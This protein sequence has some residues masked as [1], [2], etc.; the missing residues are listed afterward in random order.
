MIARP[1]A[2]EYAPFYAG[3]VQRIP[4]GSDLFTLLSGQPDELRALLLSVSDTQASTRPAPGEWSIKE[5]VGHLCDAERVFAYRAMRIARNDPTPLPGFEQDD[6]V[7]G[8]DFNVR[9][10]AGLIDEFASQRRANVLCFQP[11]T[12]A[13]T[14]RR[15]TASGAG[16]SVRALLFIMAG[17]VMHHVESLKTDYGVRG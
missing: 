17:H 5:V 2:D 12:D 4:E 10:L 8:T 6:F 7:R 3:Y 13:E 9:S 11:L 1:Q 14:N 16:V 15:G